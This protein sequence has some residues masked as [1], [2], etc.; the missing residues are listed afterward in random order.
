MGRFNALESCFSL[1]EVSPKMLGRSDLKDQYAQMCQEV[2]N[3]IIHKQ[4]GGSRRPGTQYQLSSINGIPLPAG[5]TKM[6]PFIISKTLKFMVYIFPNDIG[7]NNLGIAVH[8]PQ[9]G[10]VIYTPFNANTTSDCRAPAPFITFPGMSSYNSVADFQQISYSSSGDILII[11]AGGYPPIYLAYGTFIGAGS[12]NFILFDIWTSRSIIPL[13]QQASYAAGTT[14][15]YNPGGYSANPPSFASR[16]TPINPWEITPFTFSNF[17][18]WQT[19]HIGTGYGTV[20]ATKVDLDFDGPGTAGVNADMPFSIYDPNTK[21]RTGSNGLISFNGCLGNLIRIDTNGTTGIGIIDSVA[22]GSTGQPTVTILKAFG[23]QT[24][25]VMYMST[26]CTYGWPKLCSF[27]QQRLVLANSDTFDDTL[28]GSEQ[29]N[30]TMFRLQKNIEDSTFATISNDMPF[31]FAL[32]QTE[33]DELKWMTSDRDFMIGTSGGEWLCSGTDPT[34]SLGPL[35]VGIYLQTAYGGERVPPVR[36]ESNVHFVCRGGTKIR[37]IVYDFR[38]NHRLADDITNYAEHITQLGYSQ[39]ASILPSAVFR[40]AYQALDNNITWAIDNN[41]LLFAL[42]RDRATGVM[43]WHKHPL[44]GVSG[45][46]SQIF[47][48][49][50]LA[51]GASGMTPSSYFTFSDGNGVNHYVWAYI[52]GVGTDPAI[53]GATGHKWTLA[54]TETT[55]QLATSMITL[56]NGIAG[57]T[58][59]L[60]LNGVLFNGGQSQYL[61]GNIVFIQCTAAGATTLPANPS[62]VAMGYVDLVTQGVTRSTETPFVLDIC[63]MPSNYGDSDEVWLLVNRFINGVSTVC[64]EKMGKPYRFTSMANTSLVADDKLFLADC[65]AFQRLSSPGTVFNGFTQLKNTLVDIIADG[66]YIAGVTVDS[67][68]TITTPGTQTYTEVIAGIPY[69]AYLRPMPI[70]AGSMIG[71]GDSTLKRIDRVI[72]RFWRTVA[73]G[74]GKLSTNLVQFPFRPQGVANGTPTPMFTGVMNKMYTDDIEND[75]DILI[76]STVSLPCTITSMTLRGLTMDG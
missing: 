58:S 1:G 18:P 62:G 16:P 6:I 19:F 52:G 38:E 28:W 54:G 13:T 9:T 48:F 49:A 50:G 39:R 23:D 14:G 22:G 60:N 69:N 76:A 55:A 29:G 26:W 64:V 42:T 56:I 47:T 70:V 40:L 34:Q 36:S 33:D 63:T 7:I 51:A 5:K 37:E 66:N 2:T 44:G 72:A 75:A 27:Y 65:A 53:A 4:G 25:T 68:G 57:F 17:F 32:A 59:Y 21:A 10:Q 30:I 73:A 15:A 8:N 74:Y 20:G 11:C 31:Q 43:A 12:V 41:G 67:T 24:P 61:A 46:V 71:S 3:F 45:N 35:N